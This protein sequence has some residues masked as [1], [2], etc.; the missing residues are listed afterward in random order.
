MNIISV[1][2]FPRSVLNHTSSRRYH[3]SGDFLTRLHPLTLSFFHC[4]KPFIRWQ[5]QNIFLLLLREKQIPLPWFPPP[6][7]SSR[8][9][10]TI[11]ILF[12]GCDETPCLP[13][14]PLIPTVGPFFPLFLKISI[15]KHPLEQ[16]PPLFSFPFL[17][18]GSHLFMTPLFFFS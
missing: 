14:A 9:L 18:F 16:L 13:F 17:W 5:E 7:Y 10:L 6:S 15:K 11:C 2:F 1:S 12:F 3:F 8:P 4:T